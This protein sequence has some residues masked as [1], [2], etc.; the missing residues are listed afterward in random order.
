MEN[1]KKLKI[2][3]FGT[4]DIAVWALEELASA[5]YSPSLIVTVPDK[6]QGRKMQMTPPPAKIWA[7]ARDI[8]IFQ[9][10]SL[11]DKDTFTE[12]TAQQWDL[13]IVVAYGLIMPS[14]LIN[15][16]KHKTLNVHPSLLPKLR[17]ASPIR[18]SILGDYKDTGV[19]I[20][21]IDAQMDHGP[22]LAQESYQGVTPVTGTVLDEALARTG[23]SML[24][25]LIP[26]WTEGTLV[27]KA[28]NHDQA[29]FCSKIEKADAELAL[30]PLT[31]PK[32]RDAHEALLKIYAYDGW[33][34]A[35]FFHDARRVKIVSAH[36]EN[37]TLVIGR[38]IPEGKKEID[39]KQY[40]TNFC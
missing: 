4:P 34:G 16:P 5:G 9:P 1:V 10:A 18:T 26:S 2:A 31:L 32:G 15:L 22:I 40:L 25:E 19:T 36:I 28:Q 27:P 12:L 24:A 29:T 35:F 33:P 6:P 3:F 38:I 20:M 37:D 39:F 23:G 14:W 13:F 7:E 8:P 17:G 11:K 21:L 30:N